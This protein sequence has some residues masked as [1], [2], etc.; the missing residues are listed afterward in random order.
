MNLFIDSF[1][2]IFF[3]NSQ[4]FLFGLTRIQFVASTPFDLPFYSCTISITL[5]NREIN[6]ISGFFSFCFEMEE[7]VLSVF[8][9]SDSM[10]SEML[11]SVL[12]FVM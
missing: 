6:F 8:S 7:S 1:T 12:A 11:V 5:F 2:N 9:C 10:K 4:Y 3:H